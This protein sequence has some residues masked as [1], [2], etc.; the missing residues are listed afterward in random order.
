[1]SYQ[2][3]TEIE[4]RADLTRADI[5]A[6]LEGMDRAGRFVRQPQTKAEW[7]A[8]AERCRDAA[9]HSTELPAL[10]DTRLCDRL[11]LEIAS[12]PEGVTP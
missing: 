10:W 5:D 7:R 6:V 4:T 2:L 3:L 11:D 8:F 12:A 9:R 1:M